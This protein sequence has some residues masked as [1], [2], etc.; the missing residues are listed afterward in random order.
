MSKFESRYLRVQEVAE[1]NATAVIATFFLLFAVATT[2][3]M[4]LGLDMSFRPLFASG[5]DIAAPTEEFE[6]VFGQASGAWISVILENTGSPS[7]EFVRSA[8]RL[9]ELAADIPQV[10]EVLSLTTLQIP[11]WDRGTLSFVSPIPQY[12]LDP[13]AEEEL[14]LQYQELLDGTRF[15]EWLVSADGSKLLLAARPGAGTR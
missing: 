1:R 2:G 5:E 14:H 15:V 10:A 12:L 11:Q 13:G 9:S 8:A 6:Q 7:A 4:S 3:V